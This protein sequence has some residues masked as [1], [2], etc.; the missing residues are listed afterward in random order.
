MGYMANKE[1][2]QMKVAAIEE[3]AREYI[4]ANGGI[5]TIDYNYESCG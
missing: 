1:G 3:E 5:F 2:E 4:N